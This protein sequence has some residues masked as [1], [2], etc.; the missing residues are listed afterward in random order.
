[1]LFKLQLKKRHYTAQP[2]HADEETD[3]SKHVLK[4]TNY[5]RSWFILAAGLSLLIA[6]SYGS[7]QHVG[8]EVKI[9]DP[10][11]KVELVE[12]G[13]KLPT[14]IDFLGDHDILFLEK[15]TGKVQRIIDGKMQDAPVLD[16]KVSSVGERGMLG[17]A[18][19][20]DNRQD[21]ENDAEGKKDKIYVFL[22]YT[23]IIEESFDEK[24]ESQ[25]C[26]EAA[27]SHLYRYEFNGEKLVNPELLMTIPVGPDKN[28]IGGSLA[29]DSENVYLTSGDRSTCGDYD[30]CSALINRRG[31]N[32]ETAN[33]Q[34]GN[35]PSGAGG[36][37]F[38]TQD[39]DVVNGN[40]TSDDADLLNLYYAYGIRNSFGIDFDP[41]TGRLWDTENG[42]GFGDEINLVEPGFNSGW[43]K[44]QGIW[45]VT[46][47]NQLKQ[48]PPTQ[49]GYFGSIPSRTDLVDFNGTG[50]YSDPE[51]VWNNTVSPTAILFFNSDK[52][53]AE[54]KNDIFVAD[55]K[56][57]RIYHFEL[58]ENRT[59]LVLD[60]TLKDKVA[61]SNTELKDAILADGFVSITDMEIGPDGYLY[62]VSMLEGKIF[63]IVP[64]SNN[65]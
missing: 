24:C 21:N 38:V 54:Y 12:E 64:E 55:Y 5:F 11:L 65:D 9:N 47:I 58:N 30:S 59:E 62:I 18:I 26:I 29:L 43:A 56:F 7:N 6:V 19:T 60:G 17:L 37:L 57:G 15:N 2:L 61:D 14:A 50:K 1:M 52:L 42:P 31:L 36:I 45:P 49:K 33:K 46:E 8:A 13:L 34:D 23:E 16:A 44:V 48:A 32:S 53:G 27:V 51:F 41:V 28:H 39:G 20:K 4:L 10:K 22:F 3:E 40:S 63:R 25:D 35:K